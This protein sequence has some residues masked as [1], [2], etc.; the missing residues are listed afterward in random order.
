MWSFWVKPLRVSR[1][2]FYWV[3]E[4][5]YL[6]EEAPQQLLKTGTR[7]ELLEGNKVVAHGMIA[8]PAVADS[9]SPEALED[10]LLV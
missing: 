8:D 10:V 4:G 2:G 7:L 1:D 5:R 3:A 9:L 6:M